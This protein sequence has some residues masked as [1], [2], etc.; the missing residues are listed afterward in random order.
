MGEDGQPPPRQTIGLVC[1]RTVTR[2]INTSKL[3]SESIGVQFLTYDRFTVVFS[4]KY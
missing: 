2:K 3:N 1:R 4:R